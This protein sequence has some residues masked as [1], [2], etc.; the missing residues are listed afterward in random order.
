MDKLLDLEQGQLPLRGKPCFP[1]AYDDAGFGI[2]QTMD[3]G[4]LSRRD[5]TALQGPV[6]QNRGPVKQFLP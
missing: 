3:R 5:H 2:A 4:T 1:S 6:T